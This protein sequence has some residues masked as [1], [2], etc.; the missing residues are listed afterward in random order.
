[1]FSVDQV[2]VTVFQEFPLQTID[3]AAQLLSNKISKRFEE[4]TNC[5]QQVVRR[6]ELLSISH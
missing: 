5:N 1:M 2:S 6:V 3:E 4:K